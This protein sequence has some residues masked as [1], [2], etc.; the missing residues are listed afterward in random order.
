MFKSIQQFE[1]SGIKKL[2]EIIENFMKDPKDI[3]NNGELGFFRIFWYLYSKR[4]IK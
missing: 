4:S 3:V 2:E 1:E